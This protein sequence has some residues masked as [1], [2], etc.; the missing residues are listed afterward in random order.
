MQSLAQSFLQRA[1]ETPDS[2]KAIDLLAGKI[3]S[4]MATDEAILEF[5]L[6]QKR[7]EIPVS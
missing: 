7:A 5:L 3:R 6:E 1:M 4:G 2:W